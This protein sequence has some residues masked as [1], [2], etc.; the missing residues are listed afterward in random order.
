M[1]PHNNTATASHSALYHTPHSCRYRTNNL[2][3]VPLKNQD[4]GAIEGVLQ[5]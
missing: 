3:C 2:L 1:T 5:V 4:T